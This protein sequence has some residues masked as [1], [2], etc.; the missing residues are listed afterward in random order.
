MIMTLVMLVNGMMMK[1]LS[2]HD[3]DTDDDM[4]VWMKVVIGEYN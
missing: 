4:V 1:I 3:V 2:C